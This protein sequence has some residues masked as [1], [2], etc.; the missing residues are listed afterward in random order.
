MARRSFLS[1]VLLV[2]AMLL[3]RFAPAF[4]SS[5]APRQSTDFLAPAA[6]TAVLTQLPV[7]ANAAAVAKW[8]YQESEGVLQPEQILFFCAFVLLHAAGIADF[9]AKKTDLGPAVPI[10]P[11]RE[12]QFNSNGF[13]YNSFYKRKDIR[14]GTGYWQKKDGY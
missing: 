4:V 10:N 7:A 8:E 12:Q 14:D 9:Y 2:D 1:L 6:A 3:C 11:F 13:Q 5:P